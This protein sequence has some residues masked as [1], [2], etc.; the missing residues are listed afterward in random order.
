MT[1]SGFPGLFSCCDQPTATSGRSIDRAGPVDSWGGFDSWAN[2]DPVDALEIGV[3]DGA[4]LFVAPVG[5]HGIDPDNEPAQTDRIDSDIVM[6][7][8]GGDLDQFALVRELLHRFRGS[9][10]LGIGGAVALDHEHVAMP[11]PGGGLS[12]RW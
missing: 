2:G 4:Y 9:I 3:V 1:A 6:L 5:T 10:G 12:G 7:A 8:A 11:K